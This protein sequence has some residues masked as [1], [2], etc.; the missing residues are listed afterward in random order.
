M[1]VQAS[2]DTGVD[3]GGVEPPTSCV[4]SKRSAAELRVLVFFG[5]F[6]LDAQF[7]SQPTQVALEAHPGRQLNIRLQ[8]GLARLEQLLQLMRLASGVIRVRH[9]GDAVAGTMAVFVA[10]RLATLFSVVTH[11]FA[12]AP[13]AYFSSTLD[14]VP[15][16][17]VRNL[18]VHAAQGYSASSGSASCSARATRCAR[19]YSSVSRRIQAAT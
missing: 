15:A 3:A 2:V 11:F 16:L 7:P 13:S 10:P 4:S 9:P 14:L 17:P 6:P 18:R 8:D 1:L 5:R 19:S 12:L